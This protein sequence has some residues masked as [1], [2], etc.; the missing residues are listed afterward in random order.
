MAMNNDKNLSQEFDWLY[1]ES[2]WMDY[3]TQVAN[4]EHSRVSM[5]NL[6]ERKAIT[7]FQQ[8]SGVFRSTLLV[9]IL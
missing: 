4:R 9:R 8:Y 6:T 2:T 1:W 3:A 5:L 7:F